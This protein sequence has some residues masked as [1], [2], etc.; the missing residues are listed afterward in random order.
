ML[1]TLAAAIAGALISI[2]LFN[3]MFFNLMGH[4]GWIGGGPA[5]Q[6]I[7]R[8]VILAANQKTLP[9]SIAVLMQLQ[10]MIGPSVGLATLSCVLAHF[11]QVVMDS[12]LVRAW[13]GSD[14]AA[15]SHKFA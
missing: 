11:T 2:R 9:I 3:V 13:L 15:A 1:G 4:Q 7:I 14:R 12:V 5:P 10:D 8:A 6:G